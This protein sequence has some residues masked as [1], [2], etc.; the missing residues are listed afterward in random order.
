VTGKIQDLVDG[1]GAVL[2][3]LPAPAVSRTDQGAAGLSEEFADDDIQAT[4]QTIKAYL[5]G[6]VTAQAIAEDACPSCRAHR[7]DD[8]LLRAGR[9]AVDLHR[10]QQDGQRTRQRRPRVLGDVPADARTTGVTTEDG[11][12]GNGGG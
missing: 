1:L 6:A 7:F 8:Q 10:R 4:E 5:L 12:P 3:A 2:A 9:M 11:Q